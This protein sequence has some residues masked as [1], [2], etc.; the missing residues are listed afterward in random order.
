MLLEYPT[1]DRLHQL[2]LTEMIAELDRQIQDPDMATVEFRGSARTVGRCR[3]DDPLQ[4]PTP[5][6]ATG[7][8]Q[9]IC[10]Q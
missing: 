6:T 9:K 3:V 10:R 7:L 4:S 1:R 5:A 2:R 8:S